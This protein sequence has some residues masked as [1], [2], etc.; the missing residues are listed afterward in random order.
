[1]NVELAKAFGVDTTWSKAS[2][3]K[4]AEVMELLARE[5]SGQYVTPAN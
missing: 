2:A 3:E 4:A 1:M 5:S